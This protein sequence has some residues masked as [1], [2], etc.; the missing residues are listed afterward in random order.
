M[1]LEERG[2]G[3]SP[4]DRLL[5]LI[6]SW[7]VELDGELNA[8]TPLIGSGLFDSLALLNLVLWIE[9]Q[10]GAP[11]DPTALDPGKEWDT[12]N[13]IIRFIE[14]QRDRRSGR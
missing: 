2:I 6:E 4:Q 13:D 3:V 9:E 14:R 12:V 1:Q 7:N 5:A 8:D 11:I 10:L